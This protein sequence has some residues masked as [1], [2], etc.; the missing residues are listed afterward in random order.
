MAS[1]ST[2]SLIKE[3]SD[4]IQQFAGWYAN[5]GAD[6]VMIYYDG[7][8]PEI[9]LGPRVVLVECG[10]TFWAELCGARPQALEDRQ[11][12]IYAAGLARCRSEWLLV[13]DAD[14]F[15]F[16]NRPIAEFLNEVPD[17]IDAVSLPTA[18]AVWGPGDQLEVPFGSTHFRMAWPQGWVWRRLHRLIFADVAQH[19][20]RGMTGHL[21]GKEFI[22]VGRP[23]S[24]I[25]NHRALRDGKP[26]THR[27][28]DLKP[29]LRGMFLGHYDAIGLARWK[30]KWQQRIENDTIVVNMRGGRSEQM[31]LISRSMM[32]GEAEVRRLFAKFYGLSRLQYGVLALLGFAFRRD[33]FR[34]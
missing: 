26:I 17:S 15:V 9:A 3:T 8:P 7:K 22:R 19:L 32:R 33:I 13:V 6:E 10:E 18:E 12:A 11:S 16:G 14:E 25:G 1:Y 24:W 30:Q 5:G 2:V 23:Y 29:E 20:R 34:T 28:G 21:S 4:V 31:E 27:A